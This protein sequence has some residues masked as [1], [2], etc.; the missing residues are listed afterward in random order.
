MD[1]EAIRAVEAYRPTG[2]RTGGEALLLIEMDGHPRAIGQEAA[3]VVDLCQEEGATVEMAADEN[4]KN[5]LWE[6]RRAVS[7]AL[8]HL[9]RRKIN[10]DIVVPRSRLPEMLGALKR[11]SGESGIMIVNFGHAGDGNIHVNVMA[12]KNDPEAYERAMALV[13]RMFQEV[14][15]LGGT[16]S[17]EHGVGLT[18]ADFIGMEI[19][20]RELELM[21]GVKRLFD[22]AGL[23]NPGKI[24]S[25]PAEPAPEDA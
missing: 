9:D 18:K 10:E 22:P 25:L 1:R 21:R 13:G 2:L 14:L 16:I 11:L 15:A 23:L 3:R 19:R 12:E 20:E 4:A 7:P 17:G 6:C 5:R 24:F 8:H